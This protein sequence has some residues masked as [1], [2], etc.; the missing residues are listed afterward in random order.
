MATT[1]YRPV[2]LNELALIWDAGCRGFPPRLPD[3]PIFYPVTSAEYATQIARDWNTKSSGFAGF[4]TAFQVDNE[5]LSKYERHVVGSAV[6][7]EYWI[8]AE[9]LPRF[10]FAIQGPIEVQSAFFGLSFAGFVADQHGLKGKNA[11]EQFLVLARSWDYSRMDFVLEVS[12]NRKAIY[13]N[14]LF[15]AEHDFAKLGIAPELKRAALAGVIDAWKHSQIQPNLPA[16]FSNAVLR[17]SAE[18]TE[19]F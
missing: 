4:V 11:E 3:Q 17:E 10:N 7:E 13:L 1:L 18:P 12:V 2:G 5:Y 19:T 6:H 16:A 14:C 8:P 15:W 9:Q